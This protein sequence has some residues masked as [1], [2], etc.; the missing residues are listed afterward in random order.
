MKNNNKVLKIL[1]SIATA[2]VLI[3]GG[4]I[5]YLNNTK[6]KVVQME[7]EKINVDN[8]P[9]T[10]LI[11]HYR[12][13]LDLKNKEILISFVK[14]DLDIYSRFRI[15]LYTLGN[16]SFPQYRNIEPFID[17]EHMLVI[18]VNYELNEPYKDIA[19]TLT[20]KTN[21]SETYKVMIDPKYMEYDL[22]LINKAEFQEH[23]KLVH[24]IASVKGAIKVAETNMKEKEELI[25]FTDEKISEFK[26]EPEKVE[27]FIKA[28]EEELAEY[29]KNKQIKADKELELKT[30]IEENSKLE[31]VFDDVFG[32]LHKH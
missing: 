23:E 11:A 18:R 10:N 1:V 7:Y 5:F 24:H 26:N 17:N 28:R 4:Y 15:D 25:K 27:R 22:S 20:S 29:E 31:K 12:T 9:E 16:T 13:V 21:E 30:L 2:C 3:G 32:E 8:I 14:R 19:V 6:E